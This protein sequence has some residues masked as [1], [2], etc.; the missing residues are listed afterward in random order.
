MYWTV[1][2]GIVECLIPVFRHICIYAYICMRLLLYSTIT[3]LML[4]FLPSRVFKRRALKPAT[5]LS[6]DGRWRNS[7]ARVH[8]QLHLRHSHFKIIIII[9]SVTRIILG[10]SGTTLW[11]HLRNNFSLK[12]K[13]KKKE[14]GGRNKKCPNMIQLRSVGW[15]VD[16]DVDKCW[17]PKDDKDCSNLAVPRFANPVTLPAPKWGSLP[18]ENEG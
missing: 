10:P 11:P 14:G 4:L 6:W 8:Y 12:K 5:N 7:L 15:M 18:S 13:H 9:S 2:K 17:F 1:L 3:L 16:V